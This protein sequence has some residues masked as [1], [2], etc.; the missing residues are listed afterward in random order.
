[1][2]MKGGAINPT[3]MSGMEPGG[4]ATFGAKLKL[5][6][7]MR[8]IILGS[9]LVGLAAVGVLVLNPPASEEPSDDAVAERLHAELREVA[10]P[11]YLG[12][13]VGRAL[14]QDRPEEA[15]SFIALADELGHPL[16][17]ELLERYEAATSTPAAAWRAARSGAQGFFT[18]EVE[19]A[20]SLAGS[21]LSDF[22][23]YG[24]LRDFT[25]QAGN[26]ALGYEVDEFVLGLSVV[27]LGVTAATVGSGGA[28]MPVKMGVSAVKAAKRTG[29]LTAG[30]EGA[31]RR[32]MATDL[33]MPGLRRQLSALDWKSPGQVVDQAKAY[34]AGL[35]MGNL[36]GILGRFGTIMG[37]TSPAATLKIMRHVDTVEDLARAERV[38]ARFGKATP[39]V[40]QTLGKG[41]FKAFAKVLVLAVA[42]LWALVTALLSAAVFMLSVLWSLWRLLRR[43]RARAPAAVPV[44]STS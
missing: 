20:A 26:Y 42:A 33:D 31:L 40:F 36:R 43:G 14:D 16:P 15:E 1:M 9:L 35:D 25:R 27:G 5:D 3:S 2:G 13:Q 39:A 10:T 19:N 12:E 37:R 11:A 18:G 23:L 30:M 6:H 41:A 21:T 4:C 28:A 29:R 38:A 8:R 17:G 32:A 34:A 44:A 24:D 22:T 7:R